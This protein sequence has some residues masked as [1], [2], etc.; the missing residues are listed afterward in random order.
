MITKVLA[1]IPEWAERRLADSRDDSRIVTAA[2]VERYLRSGRRAWSLGYAEYKNRVLQEVL[3]DPVA[4]ARFARNEPLPSGFGARLDERVVEY[5]WVLARLE[6]GERRLLDAGST[7]NHRF[8]LDL[9]VL[10]TRQIVIYNLAPERVV[11]RRN[12]SY[13]YGDLRQTI[14]GN[15]SFDEIVCIST[16]EHVGMDNT[17]LY[18]TD[19]RF[20]EHRPDD[21]QVVIQEFARLLRP[22]G[23]LFLTVPYGRYQDL[24]W[25]QQFDRPRIERLLDTLRRVGEVAACY[26]RYEPTGWQVASAH[27]CADCEYYDAHS[28]RGPDPDGAAAARAVACIEVTRGS[29]RA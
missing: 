26:Y 15:E 16:L 2:R 18:S 28:G 25:L 14:L 12:V 27:T 13:V 3:Q 19:R 24:G 11:S 8:L 17:R 29:G 22:R 20:S 1:R 7:L 23:R 5:P 21:W 9:P 6:A 4:L 10:Q